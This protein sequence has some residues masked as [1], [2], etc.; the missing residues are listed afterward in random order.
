MSQHVNPIELRDEVED[1][2]WEV[3]KLGV[4]CD[5]CGWQGVGGDL[6][7]DKTGDDSQLRCPICGSPGW[8]WD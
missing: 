6:M 1:K 3:L 2:D 8:I 7:A 5:G 4:S